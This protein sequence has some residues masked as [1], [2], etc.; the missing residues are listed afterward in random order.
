MKLP[1]QNISKKQWIAII[2]LVVAGLLGALAILKTERSKPAGGHADAETHADGEHHDEKKGDG[3]D[4]AKGHG[5]TE[6]HETAKGPH[7]GELLSEGDFAIEVQLAEEGGKALL[8]AWLSQQGKPMSPAG[9]K[10][11]VTL[12]RPTGEQ[13]QIAMAPTKDGFLGA[14]PIAEPHVFEAQI[15]VQTPKEPY[16]FSWTKQEGQI[17]MSDA[18]VKAAGITVAQASSGALQ[19]TLQLPG[20]IRFNEDRT[21]HVVPRVAGVVENVSA[22]LGQRVRKGHTLAVISSAS[23]S[24][25]R[26][27][28]QAAQQRLQ[29]AR[30]TYEMLKPRSRAK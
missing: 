15:E 7:G 26:S 9:V 21:A 28:L 29:L 3:H 23:V 6:H 8:K 11:A 27:E 24:E 13:Q 14:A 2:V 20:E 25:Q 5:D 10:V 1:T 16:L 19:S 17:A 4:H 22:N 18:Q 30:T 12:T